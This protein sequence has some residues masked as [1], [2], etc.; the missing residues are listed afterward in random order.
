MRAHS[1]DPEEDLLARERDRVMYSLSILVL[2]FIVPF[3][4]NDFLKGRNALGIAVVCVVVAFA[5]NGYAIRRRRRP[6]IPYALLLVPIT[7][8][9][10]LSLATLGVIGAFWCYPVVLFVFFVLPQTL[11]NVCSVALLLAATAMVH[12]YLTMRITVRFSV[13]LLLTIVIMNVIQNII[14]ELQR[15]LV[16]QAIR[17]PLTG[18][19]NRRHMQARLAEAVEHNRRGAAP[20]S[21]LLIDVDHFK[22]INDERGHDACDTVLNGIVSVARHRARKVDLLVR[23]GGEEFVVLLPDTTEGDAV[24]V[25]EDL[26]RSIAES[27]LLDG[28]AVTASIGVGGIHPAD[29]VESWIQGAD[30]AMYA[31]KA[32]G[33]NRVARR[34][35]AAAITS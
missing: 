33:R 15:R 2:V 17:D 14:R 12:H 7:A 4:V 21:L 30:A 26:R 6:P 3:A 16:E 10:T 31:A 32:A 11:A 34:P 25:A 20:A 22:L 8:A 19:F 28:R 18:A 24:E 9:V 27:G 1:A 29:S 13:S 35:E 23:L 5:L